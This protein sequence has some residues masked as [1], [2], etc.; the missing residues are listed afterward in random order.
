MVFGLRT[1]RTSASSS[2]QRARTPSSKPIAR[3]LQH[4][5]IEYLDSSAIAIH[6]I[7]EELTTRVS[8]KVSLTSEWG[9]DTGDSAEG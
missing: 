3:Y 2:S 5:A 8:G 6:D 9:N 4:R 1:T 7:A